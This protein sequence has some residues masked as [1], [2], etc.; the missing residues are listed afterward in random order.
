MLR[1]VRRATHD[2]GAAAVEYAVLLAL[3]PAGFGT[4]LTMLRQSAAVSADYSVLWNAY[5]VTN[6]DGHRQ[7]PPLDYV[8]VWLL[9][10]MPLLVLVLAPRFSET[11]AVRWR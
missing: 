3:Y 4:P 10:Q 5:S 9:N 1:R 11:G 8:P 2:I 7:P 6:G